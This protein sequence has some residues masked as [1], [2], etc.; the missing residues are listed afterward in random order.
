MPRLI[1]IRTFGQPSSSTGFIAITGTGHMVA[2]M[3]TADII[4][5]AREYGR[6]GDRKAAAPGGLDNQR[7]AGR[8]YLAT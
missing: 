2:S 6:Y 3:L 1:L 7:Q 4:E 5:V 8:A